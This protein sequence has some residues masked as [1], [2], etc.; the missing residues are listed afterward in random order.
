MADDFKQKILEAFGVTEEELRL[1]DESMGGPDKRA[2]HDEFVRQTLPRMVLE[3]TDA[4]NELVES[5]GCKLTW[6]YEI[7]LPQRTEEY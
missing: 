7:P 4:L 5:F 2:A 1:M 6:T 3:A